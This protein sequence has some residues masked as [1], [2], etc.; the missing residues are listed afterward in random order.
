MKESL[1]KRL[2]NELEE[3]DKEESLSDQL[4]KEATTHVKKRPTSLKDFLEE[5]E[6]L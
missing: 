4:I 6:V 1:Y 3:L 5:E 2:M